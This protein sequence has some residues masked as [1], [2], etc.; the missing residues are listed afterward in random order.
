[1]PTRREF[2]LGSLTATT[3]ATIGDAPSVSARG[4]GTISSVR[5]GATNRY[6]QSVAATP[7]VA[8][9]TQSNAPLIY[10][11]LE[12]MNP[13]GST[14]DRIARY[15]LEKAW[16]RGE[17]ESGQ[18]VVEA[19][20]GSTSIALAL[21]CAQ[22]NLKFKA[23]MAEGVSRERIL[24]I[25]AYGGDVELVSKEAG[26]QGAQARAEILAEEQGAFYTRQFENTDNPAAHREGTGRE[27]LNQVPGGVIDALVAGVGTG[28]T[29]VG[30]HQA[31]TL[32]GGRAIP[33]NARPV[34]RR[35]QVEGHEG[36]YSTRIPGVVDSASEIF[37]QAN[38]PGLSVEN[39]EA[40]E[41][42]STTR[43]LISMGFPVGPSSGLNV[44]A[45]QRVAQRLGP[46][47]VVVTVLPD[48]MDRYYSTELF[49]DIS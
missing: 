27:A 16:R 33:V 31:C 42:L 40:D 24:N 46:R 36:E 20:S 39:V 21:A 1:M 15:I 43:K 13:S 41:A 34:T 28:G 26:I 18:M 17:I 22:L 14:K 19:S 30:M 4:A 12:F 10:A 9:Q 35:S 32:H 5:M 3:F 38:L 2:F 49:K 6:I 37:K 45:A 11:K 23:V 48:R 44:T 7:L 29:L 25:R 47:A 8:L